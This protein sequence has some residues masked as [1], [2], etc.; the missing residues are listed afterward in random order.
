MSATPHGVK[1]VIISDP[2]AA[3][4]GWTEISKVS[5]RNRWGTTNLIVSG[6]P[7]KDSKMGEGMGRGGGS[8]SNR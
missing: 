6:D 5:R 4:L 7:G 2:V 1:L 3:Y 8:L